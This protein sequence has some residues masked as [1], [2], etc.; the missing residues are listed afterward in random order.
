MCSAYLVGEV[1]DVDVIGRRCCVRYLREK[2]ATWVEACRVSIPPTRSASVPP[3]RPAENEWVEVA[4]EGDDGAVDAWWEGQVTK[5]KGDFAYVT[6][7]SVAGIKPQEVVELE[8]LR[9]LTG[10][11]PVCLLKRHF[12]LTP[13]LKAGAAIIAKQLSKIAA[14]TG[15]LR[16][17]VTP[18]A[19]DMVAIGTNAALETSTALINM[20]RLQHL[21]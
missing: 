18:D 6:F 9:Q 13:Q 20:V 15:L 11:A 17:A 7:P 10:H 2:M 4:F 12:P 5:I 14:L 1:L 19:S 3:H 8:R 21:S 16:L